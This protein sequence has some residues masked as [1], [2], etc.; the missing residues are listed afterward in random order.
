MSTDQLS[1][2]WRLA[3]GRVSPGL[4]LA[5]GLVLIAF[6]VP[7]YGLVRFALGSDLYSYILLVPFIS[8]FLVWLKRGTLPPPDRPARALAGL[9]LAAGALLLAGYAIALRTGLALAVDDALAFTS[10]SLACCLIAACIFFLGR[11]TVRALAFPLAFLVLITPLPAAGTAGIENFLQ[12]GSADAAYAL[13]KVAGTSV[14]YHDLIFQLPGFSMEVAPEC[15]GIHSSLVL[16]ITSL[17]AGQLFLRSPW[18]RT[19]LA[20]AVI[21]LALIR[22]GVRVF[23][24]GELCVHIGPQMIDSS[25][26]RRG[27]PIFFLLS[28][29]PFFLLLYALARSDRADTRRREPTPQA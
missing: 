13:F 25:I 11:Q 21:P 28:L 18:K 29:V 22:N 7:I 19:I 24:I 14:Y 10:L 1:P 16:F 8:L 20:V 6:S 12:H 17:V 26:H 3:V 5:L 23:T 2:A 4:L 15:S 9:V 27:G